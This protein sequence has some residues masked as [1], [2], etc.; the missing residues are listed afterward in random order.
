ME[1]TIRTSNNDTHGDI[2]M[3]PLEAIKLLEENGIDGGFALENDVL[4]YWE[5]D[6]D[7][8]APFTRPQ[9]KPTDDAK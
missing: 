3:T 4:V 8:P 6:Q 7:P 5:H 2:S 1:H 9:P